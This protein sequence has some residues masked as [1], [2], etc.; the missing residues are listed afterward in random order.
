[1]LDEPRPRG[2]ELRRRRGEVGVPRVEVAQDLDL[3]EVLVVD[4]GDK[5]PVDLRFSNCGGGCGR[6][7]R[8]GAGIPGG[9]RGEIPARGGDA[10]SP[11]SPPLQLSAV[12][13]SQSEGSPGCFGR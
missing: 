2:V 6:V 10:G 5:D 11:L 12:N 4:G 7:R 8:S 3:G 13:R 9:K 1:M